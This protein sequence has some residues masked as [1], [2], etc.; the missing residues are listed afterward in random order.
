MIL[1]LCYYYD[2]CVSRIQ[3]EV[4]GSV[5]NSS[6]SCSC[7]VLVVLGV[8]IPS[9]MTNMGYHLSIYRVV[10]YLN[11]AV[12]ALQISVD[13]H[14]GFSKVSNFVRLAIINDC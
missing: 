6:Y 7:N 12:N 5:R 10:S 2:F 11:N 13:F 14:G 9:L 3:I 4:I 1:L 8:Q